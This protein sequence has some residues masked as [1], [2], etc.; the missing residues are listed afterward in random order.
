MD[1]NKIMKGILLAGGPCD[2]EKHMV[3]RDQTVLFM[4]ERPKISLNT[5]P[6]DPKAQ[7]EIRTC[8][9]Q[10]GNDSQVFEF[11]GWE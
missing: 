5:P 8:R 6:P 4:R 3:M 9:Y 2:G 7:I 10:Q 1:N 11:K